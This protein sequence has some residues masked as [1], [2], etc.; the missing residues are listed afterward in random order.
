ML[1]P[2]PMDT[3]K[4]KIAGFIVGGLALLYL[5][6]SQLLPMLIDASPLAERVAKQ[7]EQITGEAVVLGDTSIS[8]L[9]GGKI[10]FD[11]VALKNPP[12][13]SA[14]YFLRADQLIIHVSILDA[15]FGETP[16]LEKLE[17]VAPRIELEQL[18]DTQNNWSFLY[19]GQDSAA[20]PE[21]VQII[22]SNALIIYTN[23][24][25]NYVREIQ[26]INGITTISLGQMTS[27]FNALFGKD[28]VNISQSCRFDQF[29]HLGSYSADCVMSVNHPTMAMDIVN[30][31]VIAKEGTVTSKQTITVNSNDFRP[32]G[33]ILFGH[34]DSPFS[35]YYKTPFPL[36]FKMESYA[37]GKQTIVNLLEFSSGNTKGK[38]SINLTKSEDLTTG[39][40]VLWFDYLDYDQLIDG[41]RESIGSEKDVFALN[42]GFD[43]NL[44]SDLVIQAA[45]VKF[46]GVEFQ[47][48]NTK[49]QLA[50]GSIVV[51]E[52]RV[53]GPKNSNLVTVGRITPTKAGLEYEGLVEGFGDA[54]YELA[55]LMGFATSDLPEKVFTQFRTRFNLIVRARSTTISELRMI[56]GNGIQIAGGINSYH[57]AKPR[58][59]ATIAVRNIDFAPL[60]QQWLQ[61]AS[62]FTPPDQQSYN[63]YSFNWLTEFDREVQMQL[64]L[65]DFTVMGHKGK[66]SSLLVT[67]KPKTL[68]ASNMNLNLETS[69]VQGI[70]KLT[71]EPLVERPFIEGQMR[72]SSINLG[73]AGLS[74][75][76]ASDNDKREDNVWSRTP[77]NFMPLHY[78]DGSV[79]L[80]LRQLVHDKFRAS[81]IV[82]QIALQDFQLTIKEANVGIWGGTGKLDIKVD[83]KVVPGFDIRYNILNAQLRDLLQ[84][85]LGYTN[86]NGLISM[87]GRTTFSGLNFESWI[88]NITGSM[89]VD[90]RN[91]FVQYFNLPATI[92][93][94]ASVRAVSGLLNAI[95]QTFDSGATRIG[96][97]NGTAYFTKG[98]MRTTR[99]T[100]RSNESVGEI[101]GLFNLRAW[102]M[103]MAAKF[104]LITLAQ[105][106]YPFL[107][108]NFDGAM[109]KPV[110][111]LN[112]K[113][114]EAFLAQKLR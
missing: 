32:W 105:T 82:A 1:H 89:T 19:K 85:W 27:E 23:H 104:G 96:N 15:L 37:D 8:I 80:R 55:P 92:R 95:R 6:L 17:L 22:I 50:G 33:D 3:Y 87:S 58:I 109:E 41:L 73:D 90:A 24:R 35:D 66:A 46:H 18:T 77:I 94:I 42:N 10:I 69:K 59:N 70:L 20:V 12:E 48:F 30:A 110:R 62:L 106:N 54:L 11:G 112:T 52:A 39:K 100:F 61:G 83:S 81:S 107:V 14:N 101:E 21:N 113:S 68:T 45:K 38:G 97:I 93:A 47:N 79:E 84:T 64:E 71:R 4:L 67:I 56:T 25:H 5:S 57:E 2:T 60:E 108:V 76:W 98:E 103:E 28:T 13:A 34:G 51:S 72:V 36:S 102:T 16:K 88:D 111:N 40:S 78:F 99:V 44:S 26:S 74:A 91:V 43:L 86:I 31:R 63:P 65:D 7:V 49:G 29:K 53:A 75:I 114:I 9:T